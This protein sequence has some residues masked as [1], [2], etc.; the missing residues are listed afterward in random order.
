MSDSRI[1]DWGICCRCWTHVGRGH[2][3]LRCTRSSS[4]SK[5]EL[6]ALRGGGAGCLYSCGS[7]RVSR[8]SNKRA[9]PRLVTREMLQDGAE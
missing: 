8:R 2:G 6:S 7:Y 5:E 3:T 9:P 4:T 1:V